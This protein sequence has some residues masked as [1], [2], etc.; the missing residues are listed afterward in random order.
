[1][2]LCAGGVSCI[3]FQTPKNQIAEAK[4]LLQL[5]IE[6]NN[7]KCKKNRSLFFRRKEANGL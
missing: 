3:I 2:L 7:G 1:M 4:G 6:E 5:S